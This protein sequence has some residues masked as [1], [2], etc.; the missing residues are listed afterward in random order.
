MLGQDPLKMN[1]CHNI[2]VDKL[3]LNFAPEISALNDNFNCEIVIAIAMFGE[4]FLEQ[5]VS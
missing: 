3:P 5:Y 1:L 4:K 2:I